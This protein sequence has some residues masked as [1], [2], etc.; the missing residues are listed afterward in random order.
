MGISIYGG[1]VREGFRDTH[2]RTFQILLVAQDHYFSDSEEDENCDPVDM[3]DVQAF[4]SPDDDRYRIVG[5]Q[6]ARSAD[7][8]IQLLIARK[9]LTSVDQY[10]LGQG[11]GEGVNLRLVAIDDFELPEDC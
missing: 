10:L 11:D 9:S 6:D 1:T 7:E 8:A 2:V 3:E 5:Y 4:P